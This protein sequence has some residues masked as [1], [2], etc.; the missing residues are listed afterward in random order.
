MSLYTPQNMILTTGI[1]AWILLIVVLVFKREKYDDDD[2]G[3]Y[4]DGMSDDEIL[5]NKFDEDEDE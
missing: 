3:M 5:G 1:I 4:Y 2:D